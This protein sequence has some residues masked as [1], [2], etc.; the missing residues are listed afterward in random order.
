MKKI[1]Y[2]GLS[3]CMAFALFACED[4]LNVNVDQDNP[5]NATA[6][7][8]TRL[9]ATQHA[10]ASL[11]GL[12]AHWS[13]LIGQQITIP[14]VTYTTAVARF[15][16]PASWHLL[17][18]Q[19][20]RVGTYPYQMFFT[21]A[22]A[23]F[24]D[25]YDKAEEQGAYH[26]MAAVKFFRATGFM[27]MAD[28]YGEM[29][30]AEALGDVAIPKFDDGK[31]IFNGCLADLEEAIALFQ[32]AQE[33]GAPALA[34]GD[35]WNGGDVSKWIK[36]CYGFKA[37]WLNNL[38]KKTDL[39]KPADILAAL[40]NAPKNNG[41]STII[42]HE[43]VDGAITG[44]GNYFW[45][46][47]FK[48]SIPYVWIVN[49]GHVP[50]LTKWYTDLLTN[51]NGKNVRDPRASRL[52]PM[53]QNGPSGSF[54]L[55][56]G[57]PTST[58]VRQKNKITP[59][60]DGLAPAVYSA[61]SWS[62]SSYGTFVSLRTRGTINPSFSE[63]N[64]DGTILT[65]G[66]FYARA[67]APTHFMGY[68]EM[69]FIK[70]EALFRQA[71]NTPTVEAFNAYTEGIKAHFALMNERLSTYSDATNPSKKPIPQ[72]EI[73][74]Y[75]ASDAVGTSAN[76]T[77][78]K[79]IQQKYIAL[80]FSLQNWN[81]MRRLD[82]STTIYPGWTPSYEWT[83]GLSGYAS[84]P[85]G[86]VLRRIR[87]CNYEYDYN[88]KNVAASHPHALQDNIWSYP[89]WWDYPTDDYK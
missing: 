23:N 24:K 69:C 88:N 1:K 34:A 9:P 29:P 53:I 31:T 63:T 89:V 38:S 62:S 85:Q 56:D 48:V 61:G 51:L 39:Y 76:L 5:T 80:G 40:E 41:E 15:G 55:S 64:S 3:L 13:A 79:I 4:F 77:L 74:A 46:D 37:R 6:T 47:P 44:D 83:S 20:S 42:H 2:F 22:G 26:Y 54:T 10:I 8:E 52:I 32:R 78:G 84:V 81:D 21:Y 25:L 57:V 16:G 33:P 14:E 60:I 7:I 71:N 58:D 50:Y 49:W 75:L 66:S 11:Y 65:T 72:S 45:G 18:Y 82:Y 30:Y 27:V 87:Q 17:D 12:S 35:S 67:D 59:P 28:L 36:M 70:A 19:P 73:D 68:P 43:D 86:Q